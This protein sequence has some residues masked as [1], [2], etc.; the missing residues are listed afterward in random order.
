MAEILINSAPSNYQKYLTIADARFNFNKKIDSAE[1]AQCAA[2][3]F[4]KNAPVQEYQNFLEFLDR[5]GFRHPELKTKDGTTQASLRTVLVK[6]PEKSQDIMGRVDTVEKLI[7]ESGPQL[8]DFLSWVIK[9]PF[10][11]SKIVNIQEYRR[12]IGRLI[13]RYR[14]AEPLNIYRLFSYGSSQE[15]KKAIAYLKEK[16]VYERIEKD[17]AELLMKELLG[18]SLGDDKNLKILSVSRSS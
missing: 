14:D 13:E 17:R 2:E 10:P 5:S 8:D 18:K 3:E 4:K 12:V 16:G 9:S 6:E 15:R 11:G 7:L 1:E